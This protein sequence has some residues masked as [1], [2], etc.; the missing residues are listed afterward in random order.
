MGTWIDG[1][2]GE[3]VMGRWVDGWADDEW[4]YVIMSACVAG[5][6]GNEYMHE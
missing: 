2:M 3:W 6:V 5:W 4:V 1:W